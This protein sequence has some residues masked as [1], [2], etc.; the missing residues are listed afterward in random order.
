MYD[1]ALFPLNTVLFPGIPIQLH[2][3]EPRYK[4]MI[5]RCMQENRP[6]GVVLI[7]QGVEAFGPL[8]DPYPVGCSARIV[9]I[10]TLENDTYNIT[11][12]GDTRFRIM[13][14]ARE[15][16]PYL[17]GEVEDFLFSD[18]TSIQVRQI[19][20]TLHRPVHTYLRQLREI[21][22]FEFDFGE[23]QLPDEPQMLLYLAAALLQIP[24][25]EKQP[26]LA[27]EST[28]DLARQIYRLYQRENALLPWSK[29][30]EDP[31][32]ERAAWLN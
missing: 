8:A 29:R 15:K 14:L 30:F 25:L 26:L 27:A 13:S 23:V 28:Q 10:D 22:N 31:D 12:M 19:I 32:A 1:L 11:A 20:R 24:P 6:F 5:Q 3:F 16:E 18:P 2:I 4:L 17:T 7:R 21:D 9:Q